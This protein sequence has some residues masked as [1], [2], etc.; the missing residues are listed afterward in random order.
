MNLTWVTFKAELDFEFSKHDK[1]LGYQ[2]ALISVLF[3]IRLYSNIQWFNTNIIDE[4]MF[5]C[6]LLTYPIPENRLGRV[7]SEA[8]LSFGR[9]VSE[10]ELSFGRDVFWPS[11]LLAELSQRPRCPTFI[12]TVT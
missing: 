12:R 7:V 3:E 5:F 2:D 4:N 8:E 11:C 6:Y 10:A 9:V 1:Q